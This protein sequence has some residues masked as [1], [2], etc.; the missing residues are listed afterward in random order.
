[1]A[2]NTPAQP[3][4]IEHRRVSAVD[5]SLPTTRA[6]GFNSSA[7]D[8]VAVEASLINGG[9]SA[10][11][12]VNFWSDELDAF[13]PTMPAQTLSVTSASGRGIIRTGHAKSVFLE[14]SALAGGAGE[15]LVLD[16]GGIPVFGQQGT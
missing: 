2:Q 10:T 11:I 5:V 4:T 13:V 8:E 12:V 1:M 15:R 16:V 7:F 3:E 9:T 14:V 6:K